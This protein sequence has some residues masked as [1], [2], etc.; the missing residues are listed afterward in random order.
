VTLQTFDK[1]AVDFIGL[2]NPPMKNLGVIYIITTID[3]LTR[4]VEV[5]PVRYFSVETVAQFMF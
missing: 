2:I 5:E 4:W 1:W 3:Y